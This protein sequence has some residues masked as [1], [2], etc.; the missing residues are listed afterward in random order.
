MVNQLQARCTVRGVATE[1]SGGDAFPDVTKLAFPDHHA[2][3][4][5]MASRNRDLRDAL[6]FGSAERRRCRRCEARHG[7]RSV[8]VGEALHLGPAARVRRS[9][10]LPGTG[11]QPIAVDSPNIMF[12]LI[13]CGE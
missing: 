10:R 4:V 5:W 7:L 12:C 3:E 8:K 2:I 9:A 11:G 6:E 1:S 13:W